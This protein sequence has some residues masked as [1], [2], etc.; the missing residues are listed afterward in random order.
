MLPEGHIDMEMLE[1]CFSPVLVDILSLASNAVGIMSSLLQGRSGFM[2][3]CNNQAM[4]VLW[5]I[6]TC[7]PMTLLVMYTN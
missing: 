7:S 3:S 6:D 5:A 2:D 1:G 4:G